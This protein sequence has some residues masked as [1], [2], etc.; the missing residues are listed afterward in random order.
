MRLS[1]AR[2]LVGTRQSMNRRKVLRM[3]A[4]LAT[5]CFAPRAL[6]GARGPAER[7]LALVN[8]HTGETLETV[9]WT[10]G[11]Y[12]SAALDA[13]N[14]ILRDH[15][16]DSACT[17]DLKLIDLLY[18]MK[19]KLGTESPFCIVSGYR[20]PKTNSWLRQRRH[21]VARRS[22]HMLGQAVDLY[23]PGHALRHLHRSAVSLKAGGVGYYPDSGF[24]HIDVGRVRYW[25]S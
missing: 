12:Q 14:H 13:I 16:E 1:T 25:Q 6:A 2:R 7:S 9:Y 4:W 22:L 10:Q 19:R 5:V 18:A 15:R 23:L 17:M 3:G 11:T 21:G 8:S 24:I 20:T